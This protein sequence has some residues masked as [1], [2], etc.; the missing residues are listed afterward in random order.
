MNT[1]LDTIFSIVIGG[2]ILIF[3]HHL[4]LSINTAAASKSTTT[5]VQQHVTNFTDILESDLRKAGYNV[6]VPSAISQAESTRIRI[7]ADFDNNN[8]A[9]SVTYFLGTT[10]DPGYLNPMSRVIYRQV[11]AG[12]A[13]AIHLGAT[14]LRFWYFDAAGNPL[15]ASPSVANPRLI[16]T[17]KAGIAIDLAIQVETFRRA[18]GTIGYDTTVSSAAWE[19]TLKPV[20]LR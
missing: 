3:V 17:V 15:A 14:R 11:N 20:N 9:D 7:V 5:S 18:N 8:A 13:E 6:Y 4:N 10:A 2:M 19:R 16:R 1:I 12:P